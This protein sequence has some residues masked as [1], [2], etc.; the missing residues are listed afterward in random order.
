[1]AEFTAS[2][3]QTVAQ[4]TNVVWTDTPVSGNCSIVHRE[5]SGLITLRGIPN[6][7]C[8]ARFKIT[9]GANIAA[10]ATATA[11]SIAIAINGEP[12]SSTTMISTPAATGD[13][14]NVASSVYLDIPSGCCS[15][16][17][18]E[19]TSTQ[20]ITIQNANLIVERVA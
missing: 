20:A 11:I 6:G 13:Y 7:Q 17:S 12:I 19:N 14:N 9:M 5:G 4:N 1:M 10:A 18:V 3:I 16:V 2:A 15:Q 8:R